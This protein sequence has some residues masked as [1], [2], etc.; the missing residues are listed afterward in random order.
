MVD[1]VKY[2]KG[3]W[4]CLDVFGITISGRASIH[5]KLEVDGE[6]NTP[7]SDYHYE[8]PNTKQVPST[9]AIRVSS[10]PDGAP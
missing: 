8:T 6:K 4:N 2:C 5:H 10:V 9:C 1:I 7:M 3:I